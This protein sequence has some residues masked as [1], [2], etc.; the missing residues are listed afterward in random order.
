MKDLDFLLGQEEPEEKIIPVNNG[1]DS[2]HI[3]QYA[4]QKAYAY[5]RLVVKKAKATMECGG[6]LIAPKDTQDRIATDAFLARNQDVSGGLFT[7]E[8]EDVI[9]AGREIDEMGYR[10]LGWWHSHGKLKTF[11]SQ[12]DVNGQF[13]VLNEI[14]AFNYITQREV[15]KVG[16]LEVRTENGEFIMFDKRNPERRYK[17]EVNGDPNNISIANLEV[18]QDKR[19]G[20]AYGLVVNA[21]KRKKQPYAEI[22]TRDL[23]GFCRS[24][25]DKSVRSDITIFEAGD[26][27]ID[28]KSLMYEIGEKVKMKTKIWGFFRGGQYTPPNKKIVVQPTTAGNKPALGIVPMQN[29]QTPV[30]NTGLKK[31]QSFQTTTPKITPPPIP[32]VAHPQDNDSVSDP[33][34]K[35]YDLLNQVDPLEKKDTGDKK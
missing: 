35:T 32:M 19:I 17:V 26:F 25:Q 15:K 3:T 11:F 9:K 27:I 10:V 18:Q 22:A 29:N 2:L 28:E 33:Q 21:K 34:N 23:C 5:A 7:I 13:T 30:F 16:N 24:S 12:T 6:Y 4:F 31:P 20:F 8:A 14:G 1:L